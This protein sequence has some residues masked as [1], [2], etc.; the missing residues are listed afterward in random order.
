MSRGKLDRETALKIE[1]S[2]PSVHD[3]QIATLNFS[4]DIISIR[5]PPESKIPIAAVCLQDATSSLEE[6][7]YALLESLMQIVWYREK[8][9][10]PNE[11]YAI[12]FG[13]FYAD[14]TALRMF[15]VKE[16]LTEAIINILGFSKQDLK[17]FRKNMQSDK[18]TN[19]GKSLRNTSPI[20]PIANP[21]CKLVESDDWIKTMNYRNRW[22]HN[23]PP[24]IKGLGINYERKNRLI[25]TSDSIGVT[26]GRG[27]EAEL[28]IDELIAFVKT[29][30]FLLVESTTEIIDYF[31][32]YLNK[33][34]KTEF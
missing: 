8:C 30:F 16:H 23:K 4:P 17:D 13:K 14:D 22:V 9:K 27:D 25:V 10:P 31:I 33:N 5:F 20:H 32:D 11:R 3:I 2:L 29:A 24:I 28:T 6:V 1:E 7:R 15:A 26:F 12:F 34:Q 21:I 18:L 19:I